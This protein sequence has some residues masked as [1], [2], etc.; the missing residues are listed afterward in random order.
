MEC[1]YPPTG[2]GRPVR[3][4]S[5]PACPVGVVPSDTLTPAEAAAVRAALQDGLL[6]DYAR[7]ADDLHAWHQEPWS[8]AFGRARLAERERQ[9]ARERRVVLAPAFESMGGS[10]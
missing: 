1:L 2:H 5:P 7:E 3:L 10:R 8:T 6:G 4:V 9:L